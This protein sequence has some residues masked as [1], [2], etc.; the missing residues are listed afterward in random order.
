MI[1]IC[2]SNLFFIFLIMGAPSVHA[3]TDFSDVANLG[4][5]MGR[6]TFHYRLIEKINERCDM[7]L[8]TGKDDID[9]L[10]QR[11]IGMSLTQV[12]GFL[13]DSSKEIT[14]RRTDH[15]VHGMEPYMDCN[16]E[17]LILQHQNFI[18]DVLQPSF[19]QIMQIKDPELLRGLLA[20]DGF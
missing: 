7:S 5:A 14:E 6:L 10:L 20:G 16:K 18:I 11:Q 9:N 2:A 19:A 4:S 8:S 3:T 1:K 13:G 12:E 15:V 17:E